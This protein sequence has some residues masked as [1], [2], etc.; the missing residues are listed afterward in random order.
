MAQP[1]FSNTN[2]TTNTTTTVKS[3]PGVLGGITINTKGSAGNTATV[4]DSTTGSG[5]KIATIDT[6]SAQGTLMYDV[7]FINGLTI[8]TAN[9][10]AADLT[11]EWY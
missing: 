4:F 9:G 10:G 1:V 6:T 8:V 5:T 3:L 11:V 7:L 2:I